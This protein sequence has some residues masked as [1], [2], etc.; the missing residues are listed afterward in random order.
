MLRLTRDERRNNIEYWI[1]ILSPV[2]GI[3][4]GLIGAI[5]GLIAFLKD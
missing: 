4:T 2:I 1:K 5:I 3:L